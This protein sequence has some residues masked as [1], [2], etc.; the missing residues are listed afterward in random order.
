VRLWALPQIHRGKPGPG[1]KHYANK[2]DF[3]EPQSA[4]RTQRFLWG[5]FHYKYYL[6]SISS[7]LATYLT[8]PHRLPWNL[9]AQY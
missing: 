8:L 5:Y 6:R 4:Q 9:A 1:V 2:G 3:P 7:I